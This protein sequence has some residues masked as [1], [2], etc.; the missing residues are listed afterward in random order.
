MFHYRLAP[1]NNWSRMLIAVF[2]AITLH[3]A[4]MNFKF[5]PSQVVTPSVSLPQSVSIFLQQNSIV[6]TSGQ[7]INNKQNI[8]PIKK[9]QPAAEKEPVIPVIET[10]P[11]IIEKSDSPEQPEALLE[12]TVHEPVEI[13]DEQSE[14]A[15]DEINHPYNGVETLAEELR[16]EPE[17]GAKVQEV[18]SQAEFQD[19]QQEVGVELPGTL[20]MAYPRY[21]DNAPPTYPALARKR[22]QE[23]A[24]ILEVLVNRTGKVD[25]LEIDTS[26]N[27]TL[28]DR[29]A[30]SAVRKWSFEPGMRGEEKIPMWV[31]VPVTFK[32][33]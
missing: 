13:A 21:Q 8:A 33:K 2:L 15:I 30:V 24:V 1:S 18:T 20:Q 12:N 32:L 31:K 29:A 14:T 16:A 17:K 26:S 19:V 6:E 27:F 10:P 9:E 28:L 11:A 23:G 3:M 25:E 4:L 22:G 5:S 7:P